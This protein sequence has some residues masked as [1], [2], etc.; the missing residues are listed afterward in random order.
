VTGSPRRVLRLGTRG[1][2]LAL[3]QAREVAD[4]LAFHAGITCETVRITTSGERFAEAALSEIGGKNVFV[5]EIEEALAE[6]RIDLAVHSSKDLPAVLP[7]GFAIAAVLERE[8]PRD[9]FVLPGG[10]AEPLPFD[11][12]AARLGATPR[13][14]TSSPRRVAQLARLL[15]GAQF[16]PV[17]GNLA[18][19]L[20]KLDEGQ[21]DALVLAA[22]GLF[23]LQYD[24]RISALVPVDRCVP[25]PGQGII[26]VE[27]RADDA[28]TRKAVSTIDDP[29]AAVAL[30]AERAVVERLGGGCQMPIGAYAE[31]DGDQLQ[32]TAVVASPDGAREA[33]ATAVGTRA[34]PR[35]AG[36]AAATELLARGAGEILAAVAEARGNGDTPA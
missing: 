11:A 21:F 4:R 18:T 27:V 12:L 2:E 1:S 33:R 6:G 36:E 26:A 15:P 8:D 30:D 34:D 28:E 23:R 32:V 3:F 24:A 16:L 5:K 20:R 14:G 29:D 22:A 9:A 7:D 35:E 19:R 13:I 25:A 10:D 17:R 31:L